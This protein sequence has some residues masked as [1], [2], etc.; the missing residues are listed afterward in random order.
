MTVDS[1]TAYTPDAALIDGGRRGA[2]D[3]ALARKRV[4]ALFEKHRAT[5]GVPYDEH[6]FKDFI[7]G[8]PKGRP[9]VFEGFHALRRLNAFMDD[10]QYEFAICFSR[11]DRRAN[12]SLQNFVERV[13]ELGSSRGRSRGSW[14]N[15][16]WV[17]IDWALALLAN[18]VLLVAAVCLR[19]HEWALGA[20]GAAAVFVNAW[21]AQVA[22]RA[23]AYF[24]RLQSRIEAVEKQ[25]IRL[26][27]GASLDVEFR[28][29]ASAGAAGNA[30]WRKRRGAEAGSARSA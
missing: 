26:G 21:F 17:G 8:E 7:L 19:D 24:R 13:I 16:F 1:L 30:R 2:M 18:I 11:S 10:V 27:A 25:A 6:R 22:W 9:A 3:A 28:G 29:S 14:A 4:V 23:T 5:A 15:P 12:D 20:L